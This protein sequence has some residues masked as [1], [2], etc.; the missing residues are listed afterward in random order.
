MTSLLVAAV[1]VAAMGVFAGS[2]YVLGF[3]LLH[4]NVEDE[5]RG[6]IFAALYTLVRLCLLLSMALG[7]IL[8]DVF[9]QLSESLVDRRIDVGFA[10]ALPGVRITLWLA[11]V[12]MLGAGGLA[13][14]SLRAPAPEGAGGSTTGSG[15]GGGSTTA[16]A[17]GGDPA[18][19]PAGDPAD[20]ARSE[21]A[22]CVSGPGRD[23]EDA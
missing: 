15:P 1:F 23:R 20:R 4:E 18:G 3:T 9:D 10:I 19:G 2:V 16:P 12:I 8:A 7:P 13:A 5:I 21:A 11:G 17:P 22:A 6:R 14:M